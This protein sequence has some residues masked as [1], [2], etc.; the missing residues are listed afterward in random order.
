VGLGQHQ[1]DGVVGIVKAYTTRVGEG[2]FPSEIRGA[3]G[4][5]LREAGQEYGATTGRPRRCGW[6][7]LVALRYATQVSGVRWLALTKLDVLSNVQP[8]M[9][10][11]AY[12]IDG[13]QVDHFPDDPDDLLR[14][15][16]VL[17]PVEGFSGDLTRTVTC[18]Q[19]PQGARRY[20]EMIER[21][22]GLELN[23]ISV[24]PS[25]TQTL[26]HRPLIEN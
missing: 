1:V 14:A 23:W 12:R 22:T 25:R 17:Q 20:V 16:P 13:R 6:L 7:D 21:E 26:I 2:P 24:G 10:C 3:Q 5:A 9:V 15:E 11:V 4:D 18:D 19:L 8:L